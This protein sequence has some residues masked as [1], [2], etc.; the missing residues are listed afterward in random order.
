[1]KTLH[2]SE[3][4][5]EVPKRP[6]LGPALRPSVN[7]IFKND[8]TFTLPPPRIT[9]SRRDTVRLDRRS[10]PSNRHGFKYL[11]LE[12][13]CSSLNELPERRGSDSTTSETESERKHN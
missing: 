4:K 5:M 11:L 8:L 3:V 12:A 1:M 13:L 9:V 2:K 10:K 7:K 6:H